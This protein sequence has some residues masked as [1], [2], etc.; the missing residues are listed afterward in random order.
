VLS[1]PQGAALRATTTQEGQFA[2]IAKALRRIHDQ[3]S[4]DLDVSHTG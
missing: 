1:G 2:R 3:Y 4:R